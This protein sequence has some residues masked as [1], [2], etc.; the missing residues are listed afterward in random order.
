MPKINRKYYK[1]AKK[2]I[3]DASIN[4]VQSVC[5]TSSVAQ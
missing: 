3:V 2:E 4:I 5:D 1:R